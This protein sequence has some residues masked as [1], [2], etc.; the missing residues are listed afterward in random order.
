MKTTINFRR[1][2]PRLEF[3]A[4]PRRFQPRAGRLLTMENVRGPWR[5]SGTTEAINAF[6]VIW[7]TRSGMFWAPLHD[8]DRAAIAHFIDQCRR[9]DQECTSRE[10]GGG[11]AS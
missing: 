9:H 8:F 1:L 3:P 5:A 11:F 2:P 10:R 4:P 7:E 6:I